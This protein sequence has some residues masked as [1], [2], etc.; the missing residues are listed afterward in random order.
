MEFSY[1]RPERTRAMYKWALYLIVPFC[2]FYT[3][4]IGISP[5]YFTFLLSLSFIFIG[6]IQG[7]RRARVNLVVLTSVLMISYSII[8][9]MLSWRFDSSFFSAW[10]NLIFS[11]VYFLVVSFVLNNASKNNVIISVK[12]TL[13][14]SIIILTIE[15][16]YRLFHP[17][18]PEDWTV[19]RE[20]IGWYMYKT[21]SFMYPDSNSVGL[22]IACLIAFIIGMP[23]EESYCF[24]KYLIPL[25][26]LLLGTL[27]RSSIF[28]A[29]FAITWCY[30]SSSK[31]KFLLIVVLSILGIG[32]T[33]SLVQ[34]DESFLS[35]FWIASL[36]LDYLHQTDIL[37]L[38]IG[39]GPGNTEKY[40]GVGAH[41][42]PFL[43]LIETGAIGTF[44]ISLLWFSIWR[45]LRRH[46][47]PIFM[48]FFVNG[49][50]FSTFAIPWFYTMLA[51]LIYFTRVKPNACL[52]SNSCL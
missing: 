8:I 19:I 45:E 48:V 2:G 36:V 37:Q 49:L 39:V 38:M 17:V 12:L 34:N 44:L 5:I 24:R 31:T 29:I 40:L 30:L 52:C 11:L 14:L 35:K 18:Q 42:F 43:L 25:F 28:A 3:V 46:G 13:A 33:Y 4:K 32:I 47:T 15:L 9:F 22:F 26:F 20:D 23:V 21:S 6:S 1:P 41:L 51:V 7:F 16:V 27:S 10:V 50:S